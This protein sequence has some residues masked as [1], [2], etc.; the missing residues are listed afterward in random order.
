MILKQ[1]GTGGSLTARQGRAGP[2][3]WRA[4]GAGFAGAPIKIYLL[5]NITIVLRN[6]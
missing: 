5:I 4:G 3:A 1:A 2:P 6:L